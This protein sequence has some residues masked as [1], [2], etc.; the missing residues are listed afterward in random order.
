MIYITDCLNVGLI[1][2]RTIDRIYTMKLGATYLLTKYDNKICHVYKRLNID[3][4][5]Y[6]ILKS[7]KIMTDVAFHLIRPYAHSTTQQCLCLMSMTQLYRLLPGYCCLYIYT[8]QIRVYTEILIS[9]QLRKHFMQNA[10]KCKNAR[11]WLPFADE[12]LK[13]RFTGHTKGRPG[14]NASF[15][16]FF[17]S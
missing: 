11:I 2:V 3:P 17:P 1:L 4:A 12:G 7:H 15:F 5:I 10:L 13:C 8:R 16:N 6:I 9:F 14:Q